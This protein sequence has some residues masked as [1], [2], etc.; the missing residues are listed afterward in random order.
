MAIYD[1]VGLIEEERGIR[2]S[3]GSEGGKYRLDGV[4]E[5]MLG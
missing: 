1:L 2:Q 5:V 4:V 3:S